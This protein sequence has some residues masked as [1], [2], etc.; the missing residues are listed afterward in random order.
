M[1]I[2][3]QVSVG[4]GVGVRKVYGVVIV[5]EF[6]A[7]TR[8]VVAFALVRDFFFYSILKIRDMVTTLV[9]ANPALRF[10][11]GV[12]GHLH[13]V[14]EQRIWLGEVH[15]VES[16]IHVLASVLDLEKKPLGVAAGVYI[17]LHQ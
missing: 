11:T 6:V 10:L 16:D 1:Q 2:V 5:L 8:R 17:I 4:V 12:D 14:V 3:L 9:P 15:Q 7:E 13:P